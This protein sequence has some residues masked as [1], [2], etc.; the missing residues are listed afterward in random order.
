MTGGDLLSTSD[1]LIYE[2]GIGPLGPYQT[3]TTGLTEGKAVLNTGYGRGKNL[4]DILD[5]LDEMTLS[6][7]NVASILPGEINRLECKIHYASP[8]AAKSRSRSISPPAQG[9]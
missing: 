4:G 3:G 7:N 2:I 6:D 8:F 1:S 9:I 5:R